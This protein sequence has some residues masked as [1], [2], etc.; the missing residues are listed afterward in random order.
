MKTKS[1]IIMTAI[2]LNG[3][4]QAANPL[5]E[6]YN[7]VHGTIPFDKIKTEHYLPAFEEAM[8]VHDAE[9]EAI[10]S[11]PKPATFENTMEALERSGALLNKVSTPFFNLLGAETNDEMQEIAQKVS[12]LLSEHSNA[13]QL[14]DKLFQRVKSVYE[15]KDKLKLSPEQSML[16]QKTFDSFAENGANLS[17]TDKATYKALTKELSMLTLKF[18]QNTLKETNKW[19][20]LITQKQQ[21]AGLPQDVIDM[22]ALNAKKLNKEGWLLN[23]K[24]TTYVPVMKYADNRDLRREL[25]IAY[26]SRNLQGGEFDN[27]ENIRQIANLRLQIAKLLGHKSYADHSLVHRMA[28]NKTNVYALLDKLLDAYKPTAE[29]EYAELQEFANQHGAYFQVQSWDWSYYSEKLK[30]QKFHLTDEM[31]KPYFELE[32]VKKGVFGLATKLYGIRFIKNISIPVYHPEVEAFDVVDE[33]GKFVAV[34][35]TDFHPRDG[36]RAGAWMSEFKGQRI[37]G[38]V[39]SRPHITIVMNFTR[40]TETVPALLTFDELTT[41]LHEFGHSLHGMLTKCQYESLSGTSVYRDFVE[42]PSQ[43]MENWGPEK[44][45]LDGFAVHYKTGEKIPEELVKKI[46]DAENFNTANFCLRQLSFGILD[47]AWHSIEIPYTGDVI[48]ME[49]EAM[50]KTQIL[51]VINEV[52]MSPTFNHIFAGGYAAGY[53]SYK[54]A[55]VLDADAFSVFAKNGIFDKKTANSFRRNILERGGTEHPMTLYKR[56]RGQEPSIDALLIR[57]GIK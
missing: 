40:P 37:D 14:N 13:I 20:L 55:E 4:V 27:I 2:T 45:F 18:G 28:E 56:F 39:D 3:F 6:K 47:M 29:K 21:L 50:H 12:P 19:S 33:K 53:Y 48:K 15:G 25:Y 7:T 44:A 5:L 49:K 9:I 41:F 24:A 10:V 38:K 8:K 11:N 32:N 43:V 57:T 46:K 52:A 23:L 42:L 31:L 30:A 1:F 51:P 17:E 22:L 26:S 36:K 35:Y 16:L 54:W 34:L